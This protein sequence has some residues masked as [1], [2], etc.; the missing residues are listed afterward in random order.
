MN[1]TTRGELLKRS[2]LVATTLAVG[3]SAF[4]LPAAQAAIEYGPLGPVDGNGVRLPAGFSARVLAKSGQPGLNTGYVWPGQP[5][6][7]G[8]FPTAGGGWVLACNSE[9]NG[10]SGGASAVRF[11][12]NG[13]PFHGL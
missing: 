13:E 10:T 6:G 3:R 5:D 7:S 12:A 11:A 4:H 8:T 2:A 9:L 1:T